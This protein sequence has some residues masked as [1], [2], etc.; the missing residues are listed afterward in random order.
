M[1]RKMMLSVVALLLVAVSA[2]AIMSPIAKAD[3]SGTTIALSTG[4]PNWSADLTTYANFI[5]DVH[6]I[7]GYSGGSVLG[8]VEY[9]DDPTEMNNWGLSGPFVKVGPGTGG[10]YKGW[11]LYKFALPV[12]QTTGVGGM[13]TADAMRTNNYDSSV[14][15]MGVN[16]SAIAGASTVDLGSG[17]DEAAFTK[18]NFLAPP[19]GG[20]WGSYGMLS[21]NI[22]VGVSDFTVAFFEEWSSNERLAYQALDVNAVIVPE[23]VTIVFLGL[24]GLSLL[25]R[26][27]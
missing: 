26:K 12:G 23:P 18:T 16:G 5:G 10:S 4:S 13:I 21:L 17:A 2:Q 19:P 20:P 9:Q 7:G 27:K 25:R 8:N 3:A 15:W 6:Q 11:V 22:P 24:G 1:C 14:T